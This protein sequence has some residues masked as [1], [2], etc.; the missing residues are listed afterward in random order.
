MRKNKERDI[1]KFMNILKKH[2]KKIIV[3][4]IITA[5][6]A[7]CISCELNARFAP[8][9]KRQDIS[10]TLEKESLNEKDYTFLFSQTGLGKDAIDDLIKSGNKAK[11][12]DFSE[13]YFEKPEY[14]KDFMLFPFIATEQKTDSLT[15]IAPL[16]DGDILISL[17]TYTMGYRH[18]HAGIVVNGKTGRTVEHT[19]FGER[20]DYGNADTWRE[21]TTFAV[22]RYKDSDIAKKAA[23]YAEEKLIG[24]FY[25]PLAGFF[26]KDKQD[27]NPVSSSMCSHLVWQA[28]IAVGADIDGDG[29]N[30]VMP[31]DFLKCPDLEIVQIYGIDPERAS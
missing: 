26:K 22:L 23:E 2:K 24:I 5:I 31:S 1:I 4:L 16:R 8:D 11:I 13:Q 19:V 14:K 27:E 29:G 30:L 9:W 20:S 25:T 7:R 12:Y 21:Y 6:S 3:I 18:G 28:Y 17:T 10:E 15:E